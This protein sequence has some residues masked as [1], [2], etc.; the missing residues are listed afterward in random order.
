MLRQIG[1]ST[2]RY[3]GNA[4]AAFFHPCAPPSTHAPGFFSPQGTSLGRGYRD[5]H[6]ARLANVYE[7]IVRTSINISCVIDTVSLFTT[8]FL[9]NPRSTF[10]QHS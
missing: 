3:S 2:L 7:T 1:T 8:A 5:A 9:I 10:S 6:E 4:Y